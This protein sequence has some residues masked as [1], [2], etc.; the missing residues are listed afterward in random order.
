MCDAL[1]QHTCTSHRV[2]TD[3]SFIFSSLLNPC[4][5][6]LLAMSLTMNLSGLPS[7]ATSEMQHCVNP[8]GQECKSSLFTLQTNTVAAQGYLAF[9]TCETI[10]ISPLAEELGG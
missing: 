3:E 10:D 6:S 7:P 2:V 5:Q 1:T 4:T 9:N 8:L